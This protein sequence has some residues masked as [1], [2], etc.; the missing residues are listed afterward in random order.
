MPIV[1]LHVL[2]GYSSQEKQRL[3]EALTDAVRFVVP[4]A[5]ELVTVIIHDMPTDNY[6]RARSQHA[7]APA[8]PDPAQL[9]HEYLAAMEARDLDRARAMLDAGFSMTFPATPT[10]TQL[11][12]LIEWSRPRY[13]FVTKTYEGYDAMQGQSDAAIVYCRGTLSGEN[14]DGT[15]FNGIRFIDR[16]EITNGQI[17][18]QDVWNDMAETR[19][20]AGATT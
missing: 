6:Y 19:A 2:E 16:F 7:P 13:K 5:P 11:E 15:M 8:R 18:R 1:E 20:N 14:L 17:T 12:E 3:G 10:M 4:A 9:V